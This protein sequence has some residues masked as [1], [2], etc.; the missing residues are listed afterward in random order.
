MPPHPTAM[1]MTAATKPRHERPIAG[2]VLRDGDI[3]TAIGDALKSRSN[4]WK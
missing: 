1:T 4:S 3:S 2:F